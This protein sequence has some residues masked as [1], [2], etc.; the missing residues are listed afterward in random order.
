MQ[1]KYAIE[2]NKNASIENQDNVLRNS[3]HEL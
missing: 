1:Q 2:C 3:K